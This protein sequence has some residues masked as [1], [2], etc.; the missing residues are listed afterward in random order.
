M[1]FEILCLCQFGPFVLQDCRLN[2]G[3]IFQKSSQDFTEFL[4]AREPNDRQT[5]DWMN[6]IKFKVSLSAKHWTYQTLHEGINV[7]VAIL[8]IEKYKLLNQ[9]IGVQHS[10]VV[11][12]KLFVISFRRKRM[13]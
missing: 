6:S 13:E 1:T 7:S 4:T 10:V 2:T 11:D 8:P 5:V 9:G 3:I 12:V